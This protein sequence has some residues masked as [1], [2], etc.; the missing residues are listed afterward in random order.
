MRAY[1]KKGVIH[2]KPEIARIL[3]LRISQM[4]EILDPYSYA[5]VVADYDNNEEVLLEHTVKEIS[6]TPEVVISYLLDTMDSM[7]L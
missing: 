4:M 3:A 5:D 7:L 2:M 6:E 1:L